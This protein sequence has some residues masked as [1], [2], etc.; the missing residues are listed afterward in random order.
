M[1]ASMDWCRKLIESELF[2]VLKKC[3]TS[4]KPQTAAKNLS[5]IVDGSLFVWNAYDA[6]LLTTKLAYYTG[7]EKSNLRLERSFQVCYV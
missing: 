3:V 6:T 5:T 2:K 4:C 7:A 1:A